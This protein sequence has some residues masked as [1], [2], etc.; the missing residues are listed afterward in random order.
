MSD[1]EQSGYI[2]CAT[3]THARRHPMVLGKIGGW[4]PPFQLTLP[5][6]GVFIVAFLLMVRL[7]PLWAGFLSP[8]IAVALGA[9]PASSNAMMPRVTPWSANPASR[10]R[11]A[12]T[13][14][15]STSSAT[16]RAARVNRVDHETT[17]VMC[18]SLAL[19]IP[20]LRGPRPVE[21]GRRVSSCTHR[22]GLG[23]TVI[24]R[25]GVAW[26]GRIVIVGID[27]DRD[28]DGRARQARPRDRLGRPL[29][30]G[31][32][33]VEPV[34][35]DPMP[36]EPTIEAARAL[37]AEGR[38]FSAHE[39]FEARNGEDGLLAIQQHR[40]DLVFLDVMMPKLNGFEVAQ[41]VKG[42]P[43]LKNTRI[44]L[45][46]A[47][48]QDCDREL[49]R[50]AGADDYMTKPFSPTKILERVREILGG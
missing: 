19:G 26:S 50:R 14:R 34:S 22:N 11:A 9:S 6:L 47:K 29:P 38:P 28:A 39:V 46:T 17:C 8:I 18:H 36:A 20:R 37:L 16:S 48:G 23:R 35:E 4:R 30:Y 32:A 45:L 13:A 43:A 1:E 21:L 5:Q 49:G 24:R 33:G 3:Y 7:W 25:P 41:K 2:T 12:P 31:S 44:I 15:T 40:P 10:A 42:D 27:R